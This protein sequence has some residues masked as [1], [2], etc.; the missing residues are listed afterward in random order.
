MVKYIPFNLRVREPTRKA[1]QKLASP[2]ANMMTGKDHSLLRI[3]E[4]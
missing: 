3:A 2:P 1:R 4:A